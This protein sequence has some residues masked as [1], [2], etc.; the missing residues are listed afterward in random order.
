M[1]VH[2]WSEIKRRAP[3]PEAADLEPV[4]IRSAEDYAQALAEIE[5]LWGKAEPGTPEGDRFE[6][7]SGLIDAYEREH[8]PIPAEPKIP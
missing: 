4:S 8:F 2:R 7:L 3:S 6:I 5:F 1:T